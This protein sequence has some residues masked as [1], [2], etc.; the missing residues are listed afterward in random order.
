MDCCESFYRNA[1]VMIFMNLNLT[2]WQWVD[3]V[4]V[5][6]P[7]LLKASLQSFFFYQL[8]EH[9]HCMFKIDPCSTHP[10]CQW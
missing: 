10:L 6:S 3:T 5:F 7:G 2:S 8:K 9:I 4:S 1:V